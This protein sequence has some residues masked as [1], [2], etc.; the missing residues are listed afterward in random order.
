MVKGWTHLRS[1][2]CAC[3]I[4]FQ[5]GKGF[6]S[7]GHSYPIPSLA[8]EFRK[9]YW[10]VLN[11]YYMYLFCLPVGV[12]VHTYNNTHVKVT[13]QE[14]ILSFHLVGPTDCTCVVR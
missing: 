7:N 9:R 12:P 4:V 5:E 6:H 2:P 14:S 1:R 3:T 10:F 13:L 8:N 11:V